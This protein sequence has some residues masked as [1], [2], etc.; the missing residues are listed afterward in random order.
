MGK[1]RIVECTD[2]DRMTQRVFLR[3]RARVTTT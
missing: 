1:I 3:V 2:L